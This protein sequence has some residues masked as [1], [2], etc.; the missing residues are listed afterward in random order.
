MYTLKSPYH[1]YLVFHD[2]IMA[3]N[4]NEREREKLL[5]FMSELNSYETVM[6]PRD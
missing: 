5:Q 1:F 6:F 4:Y 3:L 2:K